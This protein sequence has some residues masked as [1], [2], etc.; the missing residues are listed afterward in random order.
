MLVLGILLN[1]RG[2]CLN[3]IMSA[4]INI[5]PSIPS[6]AV[7]TVA[8]MVL[9]MCRLRAYAPLVKYASFAGVG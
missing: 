1:S 2:K 8:M 3:K 5:E 4:A 6:F 9:F 7:D